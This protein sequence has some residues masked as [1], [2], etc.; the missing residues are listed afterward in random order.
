MKKKYCTCISSQLF[1]NV[2]DSLP[3]YMAK[4]IIRQFAADIQFTENVLLNKFNNTF[5]VN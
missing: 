1:K 5:S 4:T 2:S 3:L